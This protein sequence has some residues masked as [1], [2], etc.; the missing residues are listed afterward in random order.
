VLFELTPLISDPTC[1]ERK[2]CWERKERIFD[3]NCSDHRFVDRNEFS[4]SFTGEGL[5]LVQDF[6][7]GY[8]YCCFVV[9]EALVV[10]VTATVA[11]QLPLQSGEF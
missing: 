4:F 2:N 1:Q 6:C 9:V 10:A 3:P 7:F 11:R 5:D 8:C